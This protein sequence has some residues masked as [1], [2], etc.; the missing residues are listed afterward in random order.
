LT[1]NGAGGELVQYH[2]PDRL[3]TRLVT[4]AQDSTYFEQVSLPFGTALDSESTG[5]TKRRFTSY[6]RSSVTGLDYANNRHYDSQQGRF[7]QVDP[8][9]MGSVSPES[10]QTLNLYAY[11]IN[12]PINQIDPSGLGFFSF[13]GKLFKAIGKVFKI[14]TIILVVV[15]VT[16]L[17]IAYFAPAGSAW[18]SFAKF[19]LFKVAPVLAGIV[20]SSGSQLGIKMRPI[21]SPPWNPNGGGG[22]GAFGWDETT[23]VIKT[24]T[25]ACK[26]G[27]PYPNCGHWYDKIW[28]GIKKG[29]AWTGHQLMMG[30]DEA[31]LRAAS[32][33]KFWQKVFAPPCAN[34]K[35][36]AGIIYIGS[37]RPTY[38]PRVM[39]PRDLGPFHNFP[40]LLD[41]EILTYG[42]VTVKSSTYVEYTMRGVVN[43]RTGIYEIGVNPATNQIVHR[44]FRPIG[45]FK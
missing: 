31:A 17:V 39:A 13:V 45:R 3:G 19:L 22:I 38:A 10:P 14:I 2:H 7:T 33:D 28:A 11:C 42:Q 23:D 43:G 6:D 8:I 18:I 37:I 35:C 44:F 26:N 12:D 9:G 30:G 32:W 34:G 4:N 24:T 40:T 21:G 15:V 29:A 41:N 1:P 36:Y 20:G 27:A 16:A 25:N 5:S